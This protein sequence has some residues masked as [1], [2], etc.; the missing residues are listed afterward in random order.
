MFPRRYSYVYVFHRNFVCWSFS[1]L[2][3][4]DSQLFSEGLQR[5]LLERFVRI[6]LHAQELQLG[7]LETLKSRV[8]NVEI[9]L[10]QV[11]IVRDQNLFIDHNLR[12][13]I[14]PED[15]KFEPCSIHYDTVSLTIF[16]CLNSAGRQYRKI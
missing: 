3:V 2:P 14:A 16:M 11:D 4:I 13:F 1:V 5:R 7:H 12:T 10:N 9:K 15:W 8:A 6:L